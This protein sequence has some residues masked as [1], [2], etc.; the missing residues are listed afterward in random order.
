MVA[1]GRDLAMLVDGDIAAADG[2]RVDRATLHCKVNT[3]YPMKECKPYLEVHAPSHQMARRDL[4]HHARQLLAG[5]GVGAHA[6]RP[7]SVE[8][9]GLGRVLELGDADLDG[10]VEATFDERLD[11]VLELEPVPQ[12]EA[13]L[14]HQGMVRRL[15][16]GVAVGDG[17]QDVVDD[18]FDA[19]VRRAAVVP[20]QKGQPA[21]GEGYDVLD[22]VVDG[23]EVGHDVC[24]GVGAGVDVDVDV[25]LASKCGQAL[26]KAD[27]A[28]LLT[29]IV[30]VPIKRS[31][32]NSP[33][34]HA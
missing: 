25:E 7:R 18:L 30:L 19:V 28:E 24:V 9:A 32:Y 31:R 26:M 1:E 20:R 33:G 6:E 3:A 15:V 16:H 21:V 29:V 23:V 27:G 34:S 11:L 13:G 14:V 12:E 17:R 8:L 22:G 2:G 5:R 10:G 4:E